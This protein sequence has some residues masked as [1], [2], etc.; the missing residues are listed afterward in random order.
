MLIA[1]KSI[2]EIMNGSLAYNTK[3]IISYAKRGIH[4]L[5]HIGTIGFP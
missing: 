5:N 3:G 4:L 2:Y 1:Y